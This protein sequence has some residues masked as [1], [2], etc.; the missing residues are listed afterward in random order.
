MVQRLMVQR[1]TTGEVLTAEAPFV[2]LDDPTS[3]LSG[4][5][6]L[7]IVVGPGAMTLEASDGL[8]LFQR[9]GSIVTVHEDG[10]IPFR[11]IVID[12]NWD[13]EKAELSL[14]CSSMGAYPYGQP[15]AGPAFYGAKVD[16]AS[17]FGMVWDHLQS[18]PDG[19]LGV[20]VSGTTPV[21]VG[22]A[23]T[24]NKADTLAA[25]NAAVKTYNSENAELKSLRATTTASR[26]TYSGLVD[27]RTAAS[28]ALTAAKKANSGVAAAQSRYNQAVAA[29][30]A[31][32]KVIDQQQAAADAQATV[33]AR[34]KATK[35]A[36]YTAKVAASKA[37]KDDGGA[38]ELLWWEAPD[39][40]QIIDDLAKSTPFDWYEQHS[41]AGEVPQTTI[42][43]AY[44][45]LGRRLGDDSDPT[46]VQGVNIIIPISPSATGD[47]Y[48]SESIGVGAGEGIGSVRRTVSKRTGALRRAKA[49]QAKDIKSPGRMDTRLRTELQARGGEPALDE[50]TVLDH[51]NSPRG[52]YR[53]G[54]D[55]LIQGDVP[56][57]GPFSVWHRITQITD[58][59]D[60]TSVVSLQ[61]S[62]TYT[63]GK[64]LD[65]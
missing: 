12:T 56:H 60:G 38:Y 57:F 36:A 3:K 24:Q 52:S 32:Q 8:P 23:S 19:A 5:G 30:T 4:S 47:G 28:K 64:G 40:G 42:V 18:Y 62:D 55:I 20:T 58:K 46:F 10:E 14:V 44:P 33:V 29:A 41:W 54:D 65:T 2:R 50:V 45:R 34:V 63:Y 61:R 9:W 48:V 59:S 53:V 11:G 37:E 17:I 26:K 7:N 13:G 21:R 6:S 35:D 1:A 49:F 39:C 15:W 16:P 22:T 31:Q 27:A 51:V 25:Y 43:I